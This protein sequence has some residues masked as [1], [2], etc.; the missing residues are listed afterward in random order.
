MGQDH[1]Y[2]HGYAAAED[3][4]LHDQATTLEELLHHDSIFPPGST[5]LEAGSGVGAQTIPLLQRSPGIRLTCL[6]R[7]ARSLDAA[8]A[9]IRAAGLPLPNFHQADLLALPFPSGAFDHAFVCFVLEHLQEPEAAL[10]ELRR[11]LRPSGSLTVIE[12]DHGSVLLHP[13]D[14]AA[15]A[16]IACQVALQQA[17]GGDARIGRRLAPLLAR[18]G[19]AD[20]RV[21]PRPVYADAGRPALVDGFVRRT[22][23]AMVAG[24]RDEA[25]RAGLTDE[26]TFEAGL[27]ALLRT[28][29]PDGTFS[30]TFFKATAVAP[31]PH[32]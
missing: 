20:V 30:Y 1:T 26:A 4:R 13:D 10:A 16:A 23:T 9:R 27:H 12:G 28:T 25:V 31:S 21:S 6:D 5:V 24:I 18:A 15:H 7:S 17:T 14:E 8:R 19:F 2:I 11:V 22:F 3:R 29:A 32:R